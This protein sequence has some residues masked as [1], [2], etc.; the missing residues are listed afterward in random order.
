MNSLITR[1][2]IGLGLVAGTTACATAQTDG[3]S[4]PS[5][6][7]DPRLSAL[8]RFVGR[9][10]G[11]A[12]GEPGTGTV[13]R[14]YA[15]ILAGKFIEERNTSRYASGEI[16]QH[17]GFWSFD[18]GRSRFVFR[19]FHQEGFVNQFVAAT[20]DFVDGRLVA[21][22]ESIENIPP[23][24]RARETYLFTSADAFEDIFEIAE[25]NADFQRYSHNR[26]TRA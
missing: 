15:P 2:L 8:S 24:Y 3:D 5:P 18:R 12:E 1:R 21:D 26:F 20:P 7:L 6:A 4:E 9:W 11:T 13:E 25:P 16:H 14:T 17:L 23:G 19:Q 10:R 22:S